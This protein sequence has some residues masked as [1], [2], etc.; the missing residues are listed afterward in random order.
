MIPGKITKPHEKESWF[1]WK[2]S[3]T[4]R[5]MAVLWIPVWSPVIVLAKRYHD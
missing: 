5:K 3:R 1:A 4:R 2:I